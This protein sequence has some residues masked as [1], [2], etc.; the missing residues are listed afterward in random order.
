MFRVGLIRDKESTLAEH[1]YDFFVIGAGSGGVRAA[2]TAAAAGARVGVAEERYLGGTCVNVGCVPK[3]L[4]SYGAHYSHDFRD[5]AAYGWELPGTP[6]FNWQILRENK[7]REIQRLNGI[8]QNMLEKAGVDIHRCRAGFAEDGSITLGD[9]RVTARHVLIATGGWPFVPDIPGSELAITS[10]EFF[11]LPSLPEKAVVVGG[12]YIGIELAGIMAGLGVEVTLVHRGDAVLGGFD[13]DVRDY[14]SEELARYT[15]LKLSCEVSLIE[16]SG[17]GL[18]VQLSNGESIQTGLILFATGRRPNTNGLGLEG[19]GIA[20]KENGAIIVDRNFSTTV[21]GIHAVGDVI[22]RVA[23]T[24]VALAEGEA[25]ARRLFNSGKK[26]VNY[27]LIPS[28]VFSQPNV[29]TV[30][31]TE[32]EARARYSELDVFVTRFTHLKHTLTGH[33]SKVFMKLIVERESDRVVGAH[34]VG[35][36]AAEIIQG[37]A[38]AM[39]AGA[40]KADF[41]ATLGIHPTAAEEFVTMRSPR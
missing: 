23:L 25:L 36:D 1:D 13:Q 30:G 40:T 24:P 22:D 3:K 4:L 7:D 29:G 10:N 27:D 8:Y 31:L 32:A 34:M 21:P 20:C 41:D 19:P 17:D 26:T 9:R 28:A 35:D 39:Q 18:S 16:K 5:S 38:V 14:M 12:G 11:V 2:R 37:L 33:G 6:V 15:R